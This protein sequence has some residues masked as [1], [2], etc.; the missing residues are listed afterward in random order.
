MFC[1]L[2]TIGPVGFKE[3][4]RVLCAVRATTYQLDHCPSW[5]VKASR[6]VTSRWVHSVI[7]SSLQEGT[8]L[9]PF[10]EALVCPL[11]KKTSFNPTYLDNFLPVSH[12]PFLEKMIKKKVAWQFQRV[13]DETDFLDSSIRPG[14]GTGTFGCPYEQSGV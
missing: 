5:M 11:L 1:N 6:M 4:D 7:N 9:G 8:V 12:L 3:V 14:C 10:K 2:G 13:S